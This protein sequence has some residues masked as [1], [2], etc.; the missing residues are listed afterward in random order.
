MRDR[1]NPPSC[2]LRVGDDPE[3]LA[4]LIR[5]KWV[6]AS[7]LELRKRLGNGNVKSATPLSFAVG[8]LVEVEAAV[9]IILRRS[10][11][12]ASSIVETRLRPL[13]ITK[14]ASCHNLAVSEITMNM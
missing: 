2:T 13:R 5:D 8:D 4:E 3:G 10:K 12:S 1:K 6:A 7:T 14:M 11:T 9:D